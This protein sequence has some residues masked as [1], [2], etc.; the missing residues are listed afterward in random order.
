MEKNKQFLKNLNFE[1]FDNPPSKLK[2]LAVCFK[3]MMS[4]PAISCDKPT[5]FV[6]NKTT[7]F[8]RFFV[9]A[10]ISGNY[11]FLK[12]EVVKKL[13]SNSFSVKEYD[14][15]LKNIKILHD[16]D[17]SLVVFPEK[18]YTIFGDAEKLPLQVTNFLFDTGYDLAFLYLVG[19]YFA[20]PIWAQSHRRCDTK[21][22]KQTS[23]THAKLEELIERE[24][25]EI[26]NKCMPS[27]ASVYAE[28]NHVFIRSNKLAERIERIIYACP[29]C[30]EFFSVYSEFNCLKCRNCGSAVEFSN[31]GKIDFSRD[32]YSFD[33]LDEFLFGLLRKQPVDLSRQFVS[34]D[35]VGL[36]DESLKT[37]KFN[38]DTKMTVFFNEIHLTNQ[39][40]TKKYAIQNID[41]IELLPNNVLKLYQK[42]EVVTLKGENAENFYIIIHLHKLLKELI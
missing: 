8:D 2:S 34:Y 1:Y 14:D 4:K 5:L 35:G 3:F 23:F 6:C 9:T 12:D 10:S 24:Q 7:E 38:Y 15:L 21:C 22:I 13:H 31:N 20:K 40:K 18:K 16:N 30:K 42:K 33:Y 25:N 27:S 32:I 29:H 19:T 39:G 41:D 17:W 26:L 36:L 37:P 11:L 28:K